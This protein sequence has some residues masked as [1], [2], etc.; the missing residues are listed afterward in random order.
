MPISFVAMLKKSAEPIQAGRTY[1][2]AGCYRKNLEAGQVGIVSRGESYCKT[3]VG[4]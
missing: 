1:E 2:C 3:C 4:E